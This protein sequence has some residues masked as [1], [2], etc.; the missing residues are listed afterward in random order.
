MVTGDGDTDNDDPDFER[1]GD[2]EY[3]GGEAKDASAD[4]RPS[5]DNYW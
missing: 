5:P 3:T 1:G 2:T 4:T